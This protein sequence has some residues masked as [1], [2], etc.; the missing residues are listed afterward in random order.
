MEQRVS[1]EVKMRLV[2]AGVVVLIASA[3]SSTGS[4]GCGGCG[5]TEQI[6]GGFPAAERMNNAGQIR[7]SS[8]GI[9]FM[10]NNFE[11]LVKMLVPGGLSFKIPPTGCS[12]GGSQRLCCGSAAC[13]A[14]M[15]INS[16]KMTPTPK[17]TLKLS[18]RAGVKTSK[19]PF[20]VNVSI[21]GWLKCSVEF[22]SAWSGQS[23]L[24]MDANM[25]FI[26]QAS[27]QNKLA[28]KRGSTKLVDFDSGDI[29]ITG[30][31]Y[32]SVVDWLKGLFK[33]TIE[34]EIA[35]TLDSTVDKMLKDLPLGQE[36]RLDLATMLASFSPNTTGKMDFSFWAGGQ[37]QAENSGMSIGAMSGF[38]AAQYNRCVPDCEKQGATCKKPAR[39]AIPWSKTFSGNTRPDGKTFDVGIGLHRQALNHATYAMFR[40]GGLCLDVGTDTVEQLS[41]SIFAALLNSLNTL[42]EGKNVPLKLA[43]RPRQPPTVELGKGTWT[44]GS[45]GKPV[46]QEPLLKVK[47]KDFAIDLYLMADER[48]IRVFTIVTDLEIPM[49]IYADS[50]GKLQPMLG[51]LKKALTNTRLENYELISEDPKT[52]TTL[53][54]I[55]ISLASGQ[56]GGAIS[57]VELPSISGIK[58]ILDKGS[59]TSSDNFTMLAIFAK[60]GL[61]STTGTSGSAATPGQ[62]GEI[63]TD[64]AIELIDLPRPEAF[65]GGEGFDPWGGPRVVLRARALNLPPHLVGKPLE[66]AW[67]VDGGFYRPWVQSDRLEIQS[68]V[69]WLQGKHTIEVMARVAG[70]HTT[71]D[72]TPVKVP[73]EI[74]TLP[75]EE[76][77]PRARREAGGV[78]PDQMGGC[79]AAGGSPA[80]ILGLGLLALVAGLT[81]LR[82]RRRR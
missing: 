6:P 38:R 28:I 58:L 53:M 61:A 72:S 64:A 29:K 44:T 18:M 12:G 49:L 47:A 5:T 43:I 50:K 71:T 45:D 13:T 55:I 73:L 70:D 80:S 1:H 60:L 40:S 25:D 41:S 48:M 42:T 68:P 46:I 51:D 34:Q 66:F 16:V 75:R 82:R 22:N 74:N 78:P 7:L 8:S 62:G 67:R 2:F 20:E 30:S 76:W 52:I 31:W 77:D 36:G 23:T 39:T 32:C 54:P 21:L 10:E 17:S 19:I 65:R 27:N 14:T 57:P 4:G 11:G 33:G 69:L 56:L 9:N 26:I 24:G 81:L 63:D 15:T 3:C 59:I 37:A 79:A 35:K